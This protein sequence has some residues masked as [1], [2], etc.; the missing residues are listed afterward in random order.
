MACPG[1]ID[2]RENIVFF[3][4]IDGGLCCKEACG[5]VTVPEGRNA[6]LKIVGKV[7]V[8]SRGHNQVACEFI[9][10]RV[11]HGSIEI[12]GEKHGAGKLRFQR[13]EGKQFVVIVVADDTDSTDASQLI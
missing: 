4:I 12:G 5:L 3:E 7:Q 6:L 11:Q 13:L 1:L 8:V 9:V 10:S 2:R